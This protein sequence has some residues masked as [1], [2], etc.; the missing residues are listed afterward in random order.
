MNGGSGVSIGGSGF[1]GQVL[2]YWIAYHHT[3]TVDRYA[4]SITVNNCKN[5]CG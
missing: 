3:L 2:S 4:K 1:L 5:S